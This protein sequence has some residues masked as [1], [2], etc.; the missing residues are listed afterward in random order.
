MQRIK[1]GIIGLGLAWERLHAPALARLKDKYEIVAVCDK[2]AT[3]VKE[4]ALFL[5]LPEESAYT[6]YNKM[7][8]R[9]DIEAVESLVPIS[10]N[11][12]TAAA[13]IRS[14]KHLIAEKPLASTPEA[15]RALIQLRDSTNV[16]V[17]VAENIRYEEQ[18]VLIKNL[19]TSGQIGNPI[20]FIDTHIVEYQQ[21]SERGGFGQTHWRQE[22]AYAGGVIMDSGVHHMARMR[23]FFG[24]ALSVYAKGRPSGLSF[25][26]Y[27]CINSLL[28]FDENI[29]GHY[30][31]FLVGKETQAPLVGLRIFGT[32]G[33]IYLEEPNCGFVNISYKDDRPSV[34]ISYTPGEGYYHELEDFYAALRLG[35]KIESTPE[36]AMGDIETVFAI[37]ESARLGEAIDPRK[38]ERVTQ[39]Y[40]LPR[41]TSYPNSRTDSRTENRLS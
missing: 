35:G 21:E 13:V 30:S 28:N 8:T 23:Y 5:G 25:A 29:T 31:F 32:H 14:R 4:V 10:E 15:A 11:F 17:M 18:N 7:L 38:S 27:S 3:K 40:V 19:I 9:E 37:I 36:K 22:P 24:N 12:E 6:D 20:F 33:E 34:A 1:L 16:K 41:V 2:D 39:A 26:P